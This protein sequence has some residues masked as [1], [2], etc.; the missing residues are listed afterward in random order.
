MTTPLVPCPTL[1]VELFNNGLDAVCV[2][3]YVCVCADLHHPLVL[4]YC[5]LHGWVTR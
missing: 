2:Y 5:G 4:T 1:Y 3:W